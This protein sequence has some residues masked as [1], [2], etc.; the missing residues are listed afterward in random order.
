MK[1]CSYWCCIK[2]IVS[3]GKFWSMIKKLDANDEGM[4]LL[5]SHIF[6][7]FCKKLIFLFYLFT[8]FSIMSL[9]NSYHQWQKVLHTQ[10]IFYFSWF[11]WLLLTTSL[12]HFSSF[13]FVYHGWMLYAETV[14]VEKP[15]KKD[16]NTR[17]SYFIPFLQICCNESSKIT[18][19]SGIQEHH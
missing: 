9:L 16:R 5:Q 11:Y 2:F 7:D 13:A 4:C 6:D 14:L 8:C 17:A 19:K 15:M 1:C 12:I 10:Y 3:I 18:Y